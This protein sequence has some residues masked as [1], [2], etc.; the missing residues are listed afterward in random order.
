MGL[1][2]VPLTILQKMQAAIS[3]LVLER[4]DEVVVSLAFR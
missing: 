4:R 1:F 2:C 3:S